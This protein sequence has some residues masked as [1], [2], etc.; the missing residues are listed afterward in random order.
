MSRFTS[1][2]EW[3]LDSGCFFHMSP[4]KDWFQDFETGDHETMFMGNNSVCMVRGIRNI[5]LKLNDN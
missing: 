1:I 5:T 3:V 4:N 2:R